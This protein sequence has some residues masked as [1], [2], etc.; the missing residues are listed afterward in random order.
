MSTAPRNNPAPAEKHWDGQ[1]ESVA[2]LAQRLHALRLDDDGRVIPVASVLN[3]VAVA[4][5]E[6]IG[7]VEALIESL[8]DHQPSRAVV[9]EMAEGDGTIDAH[10]ETR[11]E[12][13]KGRGCV[14]VELV[15]LTVHTTRP[16]G[17]ASAVNALVRTDL[18]IYV[19]WP[20]VPMPDDL[21]FDE[22]ETA[23]DRLVTESDREPD[24]VAALVQLN[25]IVER[26]N[27]AVTDL[28]WARITT[29]RQLITQL[30]DGAH[31]ERMR[32]GAVLQLWHAGEK[33]TAEALLFA[34]WFRSAVGDK[35]MVE[36]HP[37]PDVA[38]GGLVEVHVDAGGP[39]HMSIERVVGKE[40][41]AVVVYTAGRPTRRR[42]L[43]LPSRSRSELL[44]GELEMARR[45]LPFERALPHALVVAPR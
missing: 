12:V 4:D 8:A 41:A 31:A 2:S 1:V 13:F 33:P 38:D 21:L 18:P 39:Q 16:E 27:V 3:L 29:W 40:T 5:E 25:A 32:S 28:A 45:D 36:L 43:P 23:A 9:V 10:L 42:V 24:A 44:A 26:G 11:A 34:G 6:A 37:R 7:E 14:M 19:W 30:I 22:L 35:L 20:R 17:A 15:R